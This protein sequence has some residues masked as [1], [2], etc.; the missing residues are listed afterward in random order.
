MGSAPYFNYAKDRGWRDI[1]DIR[2]C[3]NLQP[4]QVVADVQQGAPCSMCKAVSHP[5]ACQTVKQ[6]N[7]RVG[8][9][10]K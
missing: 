10:Y 2:I 1:C 8:R 7:H 4:V 9:L 6:H 5:Q 3:C